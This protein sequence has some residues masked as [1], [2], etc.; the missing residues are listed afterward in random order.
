MESFT[1]KENKNKCSSYFDKMK[2]VAKFK[3]KLKETM[4][5]LNKSVNLG[6]KTFK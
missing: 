3:I 1:N 2:N 6:K 5:L 4:N